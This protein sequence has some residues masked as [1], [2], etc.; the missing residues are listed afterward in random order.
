MIERKY[1]GTVFRNLF[2]ILKFRSYDGCYNNIGKQESE[3]DSR[4][5][6]SDRPTRRVGKGNLKE[7]E[8]ENAEREET[9][10]VDICVLADLRG[11]LRFEIQ[12]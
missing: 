6:R 8:Y 1:V 3:G 9:K 5:G 2:L 12:L 7:I 11:E 10:S 4:V